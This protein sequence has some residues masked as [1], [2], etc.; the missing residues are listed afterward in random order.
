[1][2]EGRQ[3]CLGAHAGPSPLRATRGSS[4]RGNPAYWQAEKEEESQIL[5][6][7]GQKGGSRNISQIFGIK[8]PGRKKG[9]K[10]SEPHFTL[11]S[12]S[13]LHLPWQFAP[14]N[15]NTCLRMPAVEMS[16]CSAVHRNVT[17]AAFRAGKVQPET[18]KSFAL[19]MGQFSAAGVQVP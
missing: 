3:L 15:S 7:G 11:S 10:A 13:S 19:H 2:L 4:S 17:G 5:N 9:V 14:S 1:M 16:K 12:S 18:Q 6:S 8:I